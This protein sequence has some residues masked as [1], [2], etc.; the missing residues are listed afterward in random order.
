MER[1]QF[2]LKREKHKTSM[3]KYAKGETGYPGP[4]GPKGDSSW[5][6]SKLNFT[7]VRDVKSPARAHCDDAGIDFFVPSDFPPTR[8]ELGNSVLIPSGIKVNIPE[9]FM[10]MAANKSG[11]ATKRGLIL[12]AAIID[13]SYS[14]EVHIHLFKAARC[15]EG[16]V[17]ND[18]IRPG[19][20]IAQFIL[21]PVNY[22]QPIEISNKEYDK[23]MSNSIRGAG[24][25]SSTGTR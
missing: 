20:K 16:K 10:L 19:D 11:I 18:L 8:L 2:A 5:Q 24:G 17:E 4:C 7:K 3:I 12:G 21:V 25:F 9:G 14:G 1:S 6:T 22:A 15:K 13:E 23:I